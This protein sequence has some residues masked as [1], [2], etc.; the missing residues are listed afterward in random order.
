MLNFIP[1][2]IV[3]HQVLYEPNKNTNKPPTKLIHA[4]NSKEIH[5]HTLPSKTK[6]QRISYWRNNHHKENHIQKGTPLVGRLPITLSQ[7]KT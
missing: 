2:C 5:A 4:T 3:P 1:N 7:T 6:P